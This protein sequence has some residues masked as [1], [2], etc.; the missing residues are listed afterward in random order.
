MDPDSH[1]TPGL[2]LPPS[3]VSQDAAV[4]DGQPSPDPASA[5]PVSLPSDNRGGDSDGL[6]EEWVSKAKAIVEKTKKDPFLESRELSKIK[7]DYLK[8]R[9]NKDIKLSEDN[10]R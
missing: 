7:A 6:D 2:G 10:A 3:T 8:A 5:M 1:A 4:I 9:Y